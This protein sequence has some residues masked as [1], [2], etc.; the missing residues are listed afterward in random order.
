MIYNIYSVISAM[1]RDAKLAD[2][3]EQSPCALDLR[4]R[5]CSARVPQPVARLQHAVGAEP[6]EGVA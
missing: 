3:I 1:F 5:R 6:G 2:L 4:G